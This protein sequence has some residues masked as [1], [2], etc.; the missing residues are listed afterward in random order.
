MTGGVILSLIFTIAVEVGIDPGLA[1]SL[2]LQENPLLIPD[3]VAGPNKD[4]TYDMGLSGLNSAFIAYFEEQYWDKEGVFDWRVPEHNI[5]V[6]LRHLKH[7]IAVSHFNIWLAVILYNA[8][9]KWYVDGDVPPASSVEYANRVFDR[10]N[11]L[12]RYKW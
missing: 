9:Q 2:I 4:G 12:R 5:Y 7:L 11:K 1:Q 3:L 8:G 10:Y 6:G